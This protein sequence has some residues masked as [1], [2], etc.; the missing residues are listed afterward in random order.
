M[1]RNVANVPMAQTRQGGVGPLRYRVDE[2]GG[3]SVGMGRRRRDVMGVR[4]MRRRR[5]D[6]EGLSLD[7][8]G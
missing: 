4:E 3:D 1:S 2:G 6:E 7:G 5:V 8:W